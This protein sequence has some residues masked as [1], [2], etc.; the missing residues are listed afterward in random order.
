MKRQK[1]RDAKKPNAEPEADPQETA[2]IS[3]EEPEVLPKQVLDALPKKL[4]SIA[5]QSASFRGPL[6]PPSMFAKYDDVLPGAAERLFTMAEKEQE[7]RIDWETKALSGSI[8]S[9]TLGQWLG[10]GIALFGIF[11]SGYVA[12]QGMTAVAIVLAGG[13]L[14]GL[15]RSF[16]KMIN[17]KNS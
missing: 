14:A 4:R 2:L 7:H 6:P 8:R 9:T 12:T 16:L 15:F 17:G 13:S 3:Q 11:A 10:F 1:S 5:I